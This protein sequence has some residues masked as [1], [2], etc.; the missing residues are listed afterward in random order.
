MGRAFCT[1]LANHA[2]VV[3]KGQTFYAAGID[4]VRANA[5]IRWAPVSK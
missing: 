3:G 2:T 4:E 5:A 1:G